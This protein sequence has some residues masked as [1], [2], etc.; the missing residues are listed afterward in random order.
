[1]PVAWLVAIW[2]LSLAGALIFDGIM[3]F[4]SQLVFFKVNSPN[5]ALLIMLADWAVIGVIIWRLIAYTAG[6]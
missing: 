4:I 6:G 3:M 1:M 5:T 2:C